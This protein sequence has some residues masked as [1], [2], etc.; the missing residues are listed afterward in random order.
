MDDD[1]TLDDLSAAPALADTMD[2]VLAKAVAAPPTYPVIPA[3]LV[4]AEH[5]EIDRVLGAGGMGTVYLAHDQQLDRPVALKLHRTAAHGER[6]H[7]EAVAMAK[8]AHPNVVTVYEI[9][10]VEGRPFV[11]MEYVD[12]TTLRAW[13]EGRRW[14]EIV[15][16]LIAAA[17][18]LAA[19]H[20]AGLVHRD[21]K[22]DNIFV[23]KDGRVRVG[24]FGLAQLGGVTGMAVRAELGPETETGT[25]VGTPAYM[26]PE[27]IAGGEVDARSDQFS[28]CVTAWELL[29]GVRPF[30]GANTEELQRAIV[31]GELVKPRRR[32]PAYVRRALVRGMAAEPDARWP[33][34]AALVRELRA[35]ER[36]PRL[37]AIGGGVA[38]AASAAIAWR[39]WPVADPARAC[40]AAGA[41]VDA[42]LTP[43]LVERAVAAIRTSGAANAGDE[44]ARL[45]E[46]VGRYREGYRSGAQLACKARVDGSWSEALAV[47]GEECRAYQLG[48]ARELLAA[49]PEAA[50]ASD[51]LQITLRLPP[52]DRCMDPAVLASWR[53]LA[54][55]RGELAAIVT[56]RA[57][58]D[59]ALTLLDLHRVAGA[60]RLHAEVAAMAVRTNAAVARRL[61]LVRGAIA[62]AAGDLK[63]A[64]PILVDAYYGARAADDGVLA[65][66][67]VEQLIELTGARRRDAAA[68][69]RWIREGIAEAER[70]RMVSAREAFDVLVTAGSVTVAIGDPAQA[71]AIADRAE[72]LGVDANR[73][74]YLLQLRSDALAATGK[75]AEALAAN[76]RVI[77]DTRALLG[78]KHPVLATQLSHRAAM[79]LEVQKDD[80]ALAAARDAIAILDGTG[81]D[82]SIEVATASLN[83]GAT[84]LEAG[85]PAAQHQLERARTIFVATYGEDHPDVA[86]VDTNLALLLLDRGETAR[87]VEL[88]RRAVAI[89]ERVL[90][91]A[92]EELASGLYNLAVAERQAGQLDAA[93]ATSRRCAELYGKLQSGSPRHVTALVHVAFVQ[94]LAKQPADALATATAALELA[95]KAD[96]P[97]ALA[98]A[99]LETARALVALHREPDRARTLLRDART[100]YQSIASAPRLTEIDQLTAAIR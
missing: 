44:T 55:G 99:K 74:M 49:A 52:I 13:A 43:A 36:R 90:G 18:G 98:W 87:A 24:D 4:V 61:D 96:E 67:A 21:V 14:R 57:K 12:G 42:S 23:G 26:A 69:G 2:Q 29:C 30:G 40:D 48:T 83:L 3:G 78:A 25:V 71:L 95:G 54:Q 7:R 50:Q 27:Q 9:G 62:L 17:E 8:L 19:V 100:Y 63:A 75:H 92:H 38:L 33:A 77:D 15:I 34:M 85:D 10:E 82:A 80:E 6:L 5:Y 53:P 59:A 56:A 91:P 94:S 81:D 89:Q 51:I 65:L 73:K 97:S 58:L 79:L 45:L 46:G 1:E 86:L 16:A 31:R 88:L 76:Q 60:R 20:A 68:A 37:Y 47:R 32:V 11:A 66:V 39:A 41:E 64:E 70:Q 28:F 72:Q 22:P 93:L 35:A 84:L